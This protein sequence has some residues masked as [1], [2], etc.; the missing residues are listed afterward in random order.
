MY[1]R[2]VK[3]N[4]PDYLFADINYKGTRLYNFVS[5][6]EEHEF[7]ILKRYF[8]ICICDL[9]WGICDLRVPIQ[10]SA[11]LTTRLGSPINI[12]HIVRLAISE[13]VLTHWGLN[14]MVIILQAIFL[15]V[16]IFIL[17]F[18]FRLIDVSSGGSDWWYAIIVSGNGAERATKHYLNHL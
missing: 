1:K 12:W 6:Y 11:I 17:H 18:V 14:K 13:N 8:F 15:N 5:V 4:I 10:S 7:T 2:F 3:H 16:F 9:F